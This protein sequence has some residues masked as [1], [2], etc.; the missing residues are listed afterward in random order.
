[1][2]DTLPPPWKAGF[3][4]ATP[5]KRGGLAD[6]VARAA[7]FLVSDDASYITGTQL[8]VDGGLTAV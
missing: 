8:I 1:M 3:M 6:E 4:E 7:V 5:M 2:T